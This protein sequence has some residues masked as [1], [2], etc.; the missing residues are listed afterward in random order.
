MRHIILFCFLYIISYTSAQTYH[1]IV[2]D[3]VTAIP[4]EGAT[5][6]FYDYNDSFITGGVSDTKGEFYVTINKKIGRVIV[7]FVGYKEFIV[8]NSQGLPLE[9]DT[10]AM[11]TDNTLNE[12]NVTGNLKTYKGDKEVYSITNELRKNTTNLSHLLDKLNGVKS[13]WVTNK[14]KIGYKENILILIE[15]REKGLDYTLSLSPE[16]IKSIEIQHNPSGKFSEYDAVIDIKLNDKYLGWDIYTK[17]VGL[18]CLKNKNSNTEKTSLNCTYTRGKYNF[19]F[20]ADFLW[21]HY[22]NATSFKKKYG[23]NYSEATDGINFREPNGLNFRSNR[24]ISCG[25]DFQINPNHRIS[26]QFLSEFTKN[27]DSVKYKMNI[28]REEDKYSAFQSSKDKYRYRNNVWGLFYRAKYEKFRINNDFIYN[29]Y[30]VKDLKSFNDILEHHNHKMYLGKKDYIKDILDVRLQLSDHFI[31]YMD[32]SFIYRKY[33]TK[34][35]KENKDLYRSTDIR[36]K[37]GC[38]ITYKL[39][40]NFQARGGGNI[41]FINEKQGQE[42]KRRN[43]SIMPYLKLN[44]HPTDHININADYNCTVNYPTLEQL[45]TAE[46]QIDTHMIHVGNPDLKPSIMHK[47]D[48]SIELYNLF[49]INY[50]NKV[51]R[52]EISTFYSRT[53]EYGFIESY[54]NGKL[55]HS[56]LGIYGDYKL[57]KN[58]NLY[59]SLS[60]QHYKRKTKNEGVRRG[61]TYSFDGSLSYSIPS[62]KTDLSLAYYLRYDKIPLMQGINYQEEESLGL[63]VKRNFL[64]GNLPVFIKL[65]FPTQILPKRHYYSVQ[66]DEYNSIICSD[67]RVNN[68]ALMCSIHYRIGKGKIRK[69]NNSFTIDKEK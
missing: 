22:Y 9:L 53:T 52:N 33:I 51:Q 25:V 63:T 38:N 49:T 11:N 57:G 40:D 5:I 15:G 18:L 1:G 14:I 13:D 31:L 46:W 44:W 56:F 42:E 50:M 8:S 23:E 29:F 4:L 47:L 34:N 2:V 30:K 10:I 69:T 54:I 3:S 37:I 7:N 28:L 6:R 58:M 19:Y 59:A 60:Y 65:L 67:N 39:N 64:K 68:F 61:K 43:T 21:R 32:Y 12:I 62:W 35:L 48:L 16:R 26:T 17:A 27:K 24:N 66:F 45:S 36:H 55:H 20:S 41:L